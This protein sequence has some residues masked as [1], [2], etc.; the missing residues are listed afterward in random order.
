MSK[1]ILISIKP[2][3]VAEILNRRKTLEIRKTAPKAWA[4]YL[5]S[6]SFEKPTP[7]DVYIY[8][9][10][11]SEYLLDKD[12]KY[13]CWDKREHHYLFRYCDEPHE[14]FFQGKVVAKFRLRKVKEF[15]SKS[16]TDTANKTC[17]LN[18]HTCETTSSCLSWGE[19]RDY[20]KGGIGYAWPISDL[21]IFDEPIPL[22]ALGAESAPQSWAYIE[23][24]REPI[25]A[26]KGRCEAYCDGKL[27]G[28]NYFLHITMSGSEI[29]HQRW[30][31]MPTKS[32][33]EGILAA[34]N[35]EG[36]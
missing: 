24:D 2:Q 32:Q 36:I 28:G 30:A 22:A 34:L 15:D 1:A 5:S 16:F 13:F 10:K 21:E 9:T 7:I 4:D 20:C 8:C 31:V 12:N 33:A 19:I 29:M 11:S 17:V 26:R 25:Y 14:H 18:P 35:P 23:S 27:I 6:K 3:F